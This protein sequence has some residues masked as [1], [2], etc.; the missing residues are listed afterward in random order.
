M[1]ALL[2]L[3]LGC[4]GSPTAST[5]MGATT[6]AGV[7]AQ[8]QAPPWAPPAGFSHL[9]IALTPYLDTAALLKEHEGF[10]EWLSDRLHV[11]VEL[12]VATGYDDLGR[13]MRNGDVD[14]GE[15][16]PYAYVR[17]RAAD[18]GLDPLVSYIA[19]GAATAAGYIVVDA[20]SRFHDLEDLRGARFAFVDRASTSGFLYPHRL[21]VDRGIDPE[22]AFKQVDFLGN[23][24]AVLLAVHGGQDDAGA[25]FEPALHEL[26]A[27]QGIPA[28]A[29]RIVAKTERIPNDLLCAAATLPQPVRD[30]LQRLLL[31]L[32]V[33]NGEGANVLT[34]MRINAFVAADDHAYDPVRA[35]DAA[36]HTGG[37]PDACHAQECAGVRVG[38]P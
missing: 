35:A 30:E 14:L 9:R 27:T 16:S 3:A 28:T 12:N 6:P 11:P 15:F 10:R 33:A 24:K 22:T 1:I 36:L 38:P 18:P 4:S 20:G 26:E 7:T 5:T 37:A 25:V 13:Q 17:A 8:A 32:N 34:P 31:G 29:F 19:A 23:H 21:L 2:G